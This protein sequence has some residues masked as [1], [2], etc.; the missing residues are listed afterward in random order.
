VLIWNERSTDTTC[1]LRA[2]EQLLMIY[3]I[4]YQQVRHENTTDNI[5]SFFAPFPFEQRIFEMQQNFDYAELE[6]RLLSS[7]YAPLEGNPNYAPMLAE[8]RPLELAGKIARRRQQFLPPSFVKIGEGPFTQV[9]GR[10]HRRLRAQ[11]NSRLLRCSYDTTTCR[12]PALW[13]GQPCA[14]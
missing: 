13:T 3:G 4:D 7:S 11:M 8:L 9:D 10:Q 5:G 6:G 12:L 14:N 1:F 2:Y